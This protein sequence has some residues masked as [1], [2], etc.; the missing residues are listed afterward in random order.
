MH[1]SQYTDS[2]GTQIW[3][4]IC[5]SYSGWSGPFPH[6]LKL[7]DPLSALSEEE[8]SK[9]NQDEDSLFGYLDT[10]WDSGILPQN[11]VQQ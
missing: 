2:L 3:C 6:N 8:L 10:L 5:H 11:I 7:T 4:H 9:L 1:K